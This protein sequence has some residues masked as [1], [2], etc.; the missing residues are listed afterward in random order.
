[1]HLILLFAFLQAPA[2]AEPLRAG[3]AAD[4]AQIAMVTSAD[5]IRV[6]LALAGESPTCYKVAVDKQGKIL[7]GYV[8]GES[9]PA[10]IE[11]VRTREK[12]SEEAAKQQARIAPKPPVAAPDE[13]DPGKSTNPFVNTQFPAFAGPSPN[14]KT[15]SLDSLKG[16]AVVITFWSPRSRTSQ[17]SLM[18]VMP[19][20]N[21]LHKS[22]LD[23]VGVSMDADPHHITAALDDMTPSWPQIADQH[24]LAARYHVD[25]RAGETFVIDASHRVVAAGPMGPEIE[26]AVQQLLAPPGSPTDR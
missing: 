16:R 2:A 18:S 19:L 24:G 20:Y 1:M 7:L 22:G 25:P 9:L 10:V 12:E 8:L 6:Q 11:F 3:C 23:A 13:K 15:V 4:D 21:Q 14:G 5:R 17:N 26:K